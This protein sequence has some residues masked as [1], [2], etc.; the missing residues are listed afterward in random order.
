MRV[1]EHLRRLFEAGEIADADIE[2]ALFAA[3]APADAWGEYLHI[4]GADEVWLARL[5]GRTALLGVFPTLDASHAAQH[6]ERIHAAFRA[7]LAARDDGA[8]ERR[9]HYTNSAG[10]SFDTAEEDIL[11]HVAMHAQYHRGKVNALLRAAGHKAA[12][13]DYIGFVR[14]VAAAVTPPPR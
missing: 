5:E 3:G 7:L 11:L 12:P 2:R 9:V 10:Q 8:L 6:R 4:L 13:V 14:G 1:I